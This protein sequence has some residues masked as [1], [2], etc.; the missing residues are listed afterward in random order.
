M[1]PLAERTVRGFAQTASG[2]LVVLGTLGLVRT[3]FTDF[4]SS[5]GVA[6]LSF[7]GNPLTHVIELAAG[8]TGIAM[9]VRLASARRYALWVG[10]IGLPW[11]LLEFAVRD[12]SAD[13]F[14]RDTG[15]ALVTIGIGV[16]GL[17]AWAWSRPDG[18]AAQPPDP[19]PGG[20]S[21]GIPRSD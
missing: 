10:A 9:A 15:I 13:I 7:T 8:L 11:G 17:A 20:S 16:A 6:L 19:S 4:A 5:E 12:T 21:T 14:G 1:K 18:P 2:L 3:H